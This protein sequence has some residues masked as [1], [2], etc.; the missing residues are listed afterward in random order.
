MPLLPNVLPDV[1]VDG[2]E[3]GAA[4]LKDGRA[5]VSGDRHFARRV[6]KEK[7]EG[8]SLALHHAAA[9]GQNLCDA[10]NLR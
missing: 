8:Q 1:G 5:T 4:C 6:A 10:P 2:S 7:R 3:G 9:R